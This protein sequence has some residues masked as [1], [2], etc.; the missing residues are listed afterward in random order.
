MANIAAVTT[1]TTHAILIKDMSKMNYFGKVGIAQTTF[2][3]VLKE[4]S[5]GQQKDRQ[6]LS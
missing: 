2:L 4:M 3:T 1:Q 6:L 5:A